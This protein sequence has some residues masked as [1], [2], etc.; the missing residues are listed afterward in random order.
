MIEGSV[1]IGRHC[2]IGDGTRIID[3]CIDNYTEVSEDAEIENSAVMDRVIIGE[4]AEVKDSIVG[5]HVTVHSTGKKRTKI[6][7]TSVIA[8]DVVVA[9]GCVLERTKVYPHQYVRGEFTKQTLMPA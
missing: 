7:N 3:S 9:E 4:K 6:G 1:L 2:K 8:D 5:R